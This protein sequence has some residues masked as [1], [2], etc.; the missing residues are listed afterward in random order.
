MQLDCT[1]HAHIYIGQW[2]A[3][4]TVRELLNPLSIIL[5]HLSQNSRRQLIYYVTKPH[6]CR[7]IS[8]QV[9]DNLFSHLISQGSV[10]QSLDPFADWAP[11]AHEIM[12]ISSKVE[13]VE[14]K[15]G[16]KWTVPSEDQGSSLLLFYCSSTSKYLRTNSWMDRRNLNNCKSTI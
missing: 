15:T 5:V 2:A 9:K 11:L 4:V 16:K 3:L 10:F 14:N 12:I 8:K 1:G 7:F 6:C 13:N